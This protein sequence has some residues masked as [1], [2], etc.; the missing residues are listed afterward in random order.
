M[1]A[2][3][4]DI[5]II[6]NFIIGKTTDEEIERTESQILKV[7][8]LLTEGDVIKEEKRLS[9]DVHYKKNLVSIY[10]ICVVYTL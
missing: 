5:H 6:K 2:L 8:P 10:N 1:D 4:A 9:T 7:Y 3:I